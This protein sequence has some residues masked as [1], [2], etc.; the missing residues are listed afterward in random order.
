MVQDCSGWRFAHATHLRKIKAGCDMMQ[1]HYPERLEASVVMN[2]P[3]IFNASWKVIQPWIDPRTVAKITFASGN[4]EILA[5]FEKA[6]IP[7]ALV[8]ADY[9]G[10]GPAVA[11]SPCPN[12]PPEPDVDVPEPDN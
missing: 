4:A 9:G 1:N 8:P 2:A 11:D 3:W 6:R 10:A 5:A 7:L 12:M